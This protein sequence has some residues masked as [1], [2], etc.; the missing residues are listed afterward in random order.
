MQLSMSMIICRP[1]CDLVWLASLQAMMSVSA[2]CTDMT[3]ANYCTQ[4]K[5][6]FDSNPPPVVDST[7]TCSLSGSCDH[8]PMGMVIQ[9]RRSAELI[10]TL[11]MGVQVNKVA[12]VVASRV[13]KVLVGAR[14]SSNN[15][16]A[17]VA[18]LKRWNRKLEY[19][20]HRLY[21]IIDKLSSGNASGLTAELKAKSNSKGQ[22]S[23]H[24]VKRLEDQNRNL[25][26]PRHLLR[27]THHC[28]WGRISPCEI[29]WPLKFTLSQIQK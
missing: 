11:C 26:V 1:N 8:A 3:P 29:F 12:T 2:M 5:F 24:L 14:R 6:V 10:L 21:E 9:S 27:M 25:Q 13:A 17:L 20:N 18:E 4:L 15:N 19:E 28:V 16:T 23:A 22:E 7:A